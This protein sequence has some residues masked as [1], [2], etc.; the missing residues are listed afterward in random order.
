VSDQLTGT[1]G[2][3][4]AAA[5]QYSRHE[6]IAREAKVSA[7]TVRRLLGRGHVRTALAREATLRLRSVTVVLARHATRAAEDLGRMATGEIEAHGGRVRACVAVLE[8]AARAVE[9]EDFVVRLQ[10]LEAAAAERKDA[11]KDWPQ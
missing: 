1:E 7:R 6:D 2:R 10:Q 8:Y 4:I 5:L 11:G 3:V 9:V